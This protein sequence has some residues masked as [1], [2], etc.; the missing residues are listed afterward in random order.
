MQTTHAQE[1]KRGD[2][3]GFGENWAQFLTTL[4]ERRL[5]SARQALSDMLGATDLTGLR[6][7]DAGSGSGL[8]SYAARSFGAEVHSFDYDPQSVACTREMRR[9]FFDGDPAWTVE[10]GSVLDRDYLAGLGQFDVVYSWGVLHHTGQMWRAIDGVAALTKPGG[11]L[12]IAIY[13]NMGGKSRLW[14]AIK[15]TYCGLPKALRAP[16]AMA[17]TAPIQ[18]WSIFVHL[19]QGKLGRYVDYIRHYRERR[20]MSWWHDQLDWIGGYPYEDAK[21]EEV[22]ERLHSQGFSLKKLKTYGGGV[23]CNEFVFERTAGV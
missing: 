7:L 23:G 2:R 15:R 4:D 20:G 18:L 1:M 8:S 10:E 11:T 22:F 9:R 17:V 3:F 13:N 19:I 5:A 6:F 12:F 14:T 21:P 16:F